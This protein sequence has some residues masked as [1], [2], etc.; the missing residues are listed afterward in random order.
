[1]SRATA[2]GSVLVRI[3]AGGRLELYA[4]DDAR[5]S[6]TVVDHAGRGPVETA[7][8]ET[9]PGVEPE[10][11]GPTRPAH[12]SVALSDHVTYT[13]RVR[14]S[15]SEG[16]PI[17]LFLTAGGIPRRAAARIVSAGPDG[18]WIRGVDT[19]GLLRGPDRRSAVIG[20]TRDDQVRLIGAG[21]SNV[22]TDDAG[23]Y[24][25]ITAPEGRLVLP[26]VA[27]DVR[28]VRVEAFANAGGP[29]SLT[30]RVNGT[31][32]GAQPIGDGWRSYDWSVPPPVAEALGRGPVEL[33]IVVDGP[34]TARR[35]AVSSVRF[36]SGDGP[37]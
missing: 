3:P 2:S 28:Q 21:W 17:T 19:A 12:A 24:R 26:R 18:G 23:P 1:M 5:L 7:A 16:T 25:W 29:A 36:S 14:A 30:L 32:L 4:S 27:L 10:A 8:F 13:T 11:D 20:M 37:R 34:V 35:L 6:A 31:V 33:D 15:A 22:E 9:P